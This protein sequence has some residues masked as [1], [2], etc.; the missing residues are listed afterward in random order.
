MKR[1]NLGDSVGWT[2]LVSIPE[3]ALTK[4]LEV[5]LV[6]YGK[7]A[8]FSW[9]ATH[10]LPSTKYNEGRLMRTALVGWGKN[11]EEACDCL[12]KRVADLWEHI[13]NVPRNKLSP[14]AQ[15]QQRYL[16]ALI[17]E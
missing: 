7:E 6:A 16:M 14:E 12:T 3:Y 13:K 15:V 8:G 5:E 9:T 1:R 11:L 10:Y 17:S 4:R 2:T